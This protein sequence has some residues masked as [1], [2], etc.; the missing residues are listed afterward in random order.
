MLSGHRVHHRLIFDNVVPFVYLL[1]CFVAQVLIHLVTRTI[2]VVL[3]IDIG[4]YYT[5]RGETM[6][7]SI[8]PVEN[9]KKL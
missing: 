2:V 5:M 3:N 1:F 4:T 9:L 6:W 7:N 8:A